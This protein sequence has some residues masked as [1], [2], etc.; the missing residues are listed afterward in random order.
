MYSFIYSFTH[1]L[2]ID[3][4]IAFYS[5][6]IFIFFSYINNVIKE[7]KLKYNILKNDF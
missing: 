7:V 1:L 2:I 6:I 4:L 3:L 5:Y